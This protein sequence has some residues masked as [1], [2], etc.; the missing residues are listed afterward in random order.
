MPGG[1]DDDDLSDS[2]VVVPRVPGP[3]VRLA[4]GGAVR[5]RDGLDDLIDELLPDTSEG[6]GAVD[7]TLIA[8]GGALLG[9]GALGSPPA[10]ATVAGAVA[11]GLGCILPARA[12]WRALSGRRR[13][14]RRAALLAGGAPLRVDDPVLARLAAG[15]EALDAMPATTAEAQA[16]AHGALL[17]VA[18]LLSGRPPASDRERTYV[19][20]R[21]AAVEALVDALEDAHPAQLGSVHPDLVVEA[22]EELDALAGTSALS[23]LGDVTAEVRARGRAR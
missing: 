8:G 11:F 9:W 7:A 3:L 10:A 17:E 18:S 13:A 16:A 19:E 20:E 12:A 15:Y 6:P 21:A 23:R 14:R 22:R 1:R 5:H 4:E 2:F